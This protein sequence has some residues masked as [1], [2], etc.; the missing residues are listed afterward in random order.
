[1]RRKQKNLRPKV[2]F[3]ASVILAGLKSPKGGSG[4]LISLAG[5]KKIRGFISEI[6]FDEVKSHAGKVGFS[7]FEIKSEVDKTM[8]IGKYPPRLKTK[9]RRLVKDEGDIHLFTSSEQ[10]GVD[11]LVSLDKKH[12]LA[13]SG[14]IRGFKIV[15]PG[16]LLKLLE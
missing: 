9:Y 16:E 10:L 13:L 7:R 15:S 1:M 11:Y 3:N 4:K 2:F 6:V 8:L 14:K 12:V 5:E